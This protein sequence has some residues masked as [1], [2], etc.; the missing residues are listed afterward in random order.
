MGKEKYFRPAKVQYSEEEWKARLTDEQYRVM[1]EKGTEYPCSGEYYNNKEKGIYQCAGCGLPLFRSTEKFE[2]GTGWPSF[3]D[4]I[5]EK[6]LTY[7]E[8][9]KLGMLRIE[10]LCGACD[11]HLGH[12]FE[13]GPAPTHKRYCINSVALLFTKN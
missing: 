13:D 10:V 3:F 12:V 7:I 6:N 5:S 11:S 8:D 1:R 4:P 9:H 2:S